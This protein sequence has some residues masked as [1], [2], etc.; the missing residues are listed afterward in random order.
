MSEKIVQ[1][2][3]TE[4]YVKDYKEYALYVERH[5]TTPEFRD[6]LKP[7]QRRILYTAKFISNAVMNRKSADI[8]GSTMGRY[9][10]HGDSSIYGALCTMTNWFQTKIPLFKGQG[11]FGN[12]Y[13]NVPASYRYTEVKLSNFAQECILDEITSFKEVVDWEPNFDESRKEPSFLPC[14]VPLLLING[15]SGI[16]VGDKVDIPSHN[17]NEVIDTTIALIK[18]PKAKFVLIPDHCQ[19]CE[20]V[21]TDWSDINTK[22]YGNYKVRG[23]IDI[24]PYNGVEKRYKNCQTLVIKSCPNLTFLE[25]AINRLIDMIK[26]NKIIGIIDLE[27]QSSENNMRYVIVLKPGTDPNYIRN[28]I[29][30]NTVLFQTARVNLKVLDINDKEHPAKRLSYRGYLLSWIAFRK[31]TKLR[32][33]EHK[34]QKLMTRY[35][36]VSLYIMAI[37]KGISDDII[38]IIKNTKTSDDNVLIEALIKKCKIT[39]IQAKFFINC[40][41]KKLS[42]GYFNSF[43]EEEK[44]LVN[45]IKYYTDIVVTDGTIEQVII[46]E[47]KD[48][49]AK[50]GEP[51]KCK[52]IP[53]SEI[54]GVTSGTFKVVITENNFIKKIGVNDPINKPKN[55]DNIKF[56]LTG[57]NSRSILLFDEYGKVYNIPIS[58]IPFADKNSN[59]IDIRLINKYINSKITAVIYD[60]VMEQYN[61]GFIVT[62]TKNGFIKRMTTSD[63]LNVTLSGLVYCKLDDN[64]KIIDILLFNNNAEIVVY[65]NKK[66]LRIDINE[67]PILKRNS[68]GCVSL[69]SKTVNVEGMSVIS[70][71]FKDII[72]ITKN[73]YVNKIIPDCVQKGRGKAGSNVIKLSKTDSIISIFGVNPLDI[74][75]ITISTG[76][77]IEIPVK[78]IPSGTSI[79]T[80]TKMIKGGEIVRINKKG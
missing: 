4:Q 57:D 2:K 27:E 40:E 14:K 36:V 37:E 58:K 64:D 38:N 20:I 5:R 69:S 33:C 39:D 78:D 49:K 11:N 32:F 74:L 79:G 18:N 62:L 28:E 61:K 24:E 3:A 13:Q 8:V 76:E 29:Y 34:L 21:D 9:H 60:V 51:R 54:N 47:L 19:E 73:G 1:T 46:N 15:C 16:S 65:G 23:I 35:H 6:G 17:I 31:V 68:R 59:G 30:K 66:A 52:L 56:V 41:L 63:F 26:K 7:V 48:I 70:K 53:E 72:V 55:N 10:P 12:T 50:Y 75:N 25:T 44:K 77:I 71:A 45:E 42:R 80:G 43:K 67:I 22:G